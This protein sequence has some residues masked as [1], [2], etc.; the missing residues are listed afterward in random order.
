M[1]ASA[2]AA[3]LARDL[4]TLRR[5]IEA[6]PDDQSPWQSVPGISNTAGTL[7]L[8]LAGNVQHFIGATLGGSGYRRDRQAEFSRRDVPRAELLR[9]VATAE[10]ALDALHRLSETQLRGD[11]PEVV[12]GSRV[13]A[14]EFLVHL[15]A[16]FTYHLGQIDY[17]RR[18]VTGRASPVGAVQP[19]GLPSARPAG[20]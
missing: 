15:V 12:G 19:A 3:A 14:S 5:E 9:E 7:A 11:F 17:H 6:Y 10:A 8:H 1:L 13:A 18:V 20:A 2:V 4:G 16:H